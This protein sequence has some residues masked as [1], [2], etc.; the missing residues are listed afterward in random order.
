MHGRYGTRGRARAGTGGEPGP[1]RDASR[2]I[3]SRA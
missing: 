1:T 3:P 2:S